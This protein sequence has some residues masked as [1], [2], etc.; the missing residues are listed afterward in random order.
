MY[1]WASI[2]IGLAALSGAAGIMESA[3]SAHTI[4]DPLL[5]TSANML[6]VNAA[7][8]I[9]ISGYASS[10]LQR[11]ALFGAATL[12]AGSLLFCGELSTHVFLGQ[13]SFALA[14]PIGGTLMIAGWVIAAASAF[15]SAFRR[16]D[17]I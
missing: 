5:K 1:K 7:S 13:R 6:I 16:R 14:A 4:S 11:W 15:T 17:K 9:A 12:L 3:A 10:R 2:V 8:V